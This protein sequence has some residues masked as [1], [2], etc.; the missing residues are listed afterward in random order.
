MTGRN[1]YPSYILETCKSSLLSLTF[2]FYS[3]ANCYLISNLGKPP[4]PRISVRDNT[5]KKKIVQVYFKIP[6]AK[7]GIFHSD[8]NS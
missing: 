6:M 2:A 8:V 1:Y 4:F 3:S 7:Q 5:A